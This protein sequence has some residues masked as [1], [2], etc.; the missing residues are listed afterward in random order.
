MGTIGSWSY[1]F[2]AICFYV[3]LFCSSNELH[4]GAAEKEMVKVGVIID[5]NSIVGRYIDMA[6]SDF[7]AEH[8]SYRTRLSLC[9]M[10][11]QKDVVAAASAGR[12]QS[13]LIMLHAHMYAHTTS[14]KGVELTA[15]KFVFGSGNPV[16]K[17]GIRSP[18]RG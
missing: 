13:G 18:E 2:L 16:P 3:P 17:Y 8:A 1:K 9:S 14:G 6:L 12:H 7:Y 10:D 4:V 15:N 5:N 11:S